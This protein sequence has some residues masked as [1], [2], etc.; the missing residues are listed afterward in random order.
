L[1]RDKHDMLVTIAIPCYEMQGR[2]AE[3]LDFGLSRIACQ[4]YPLIEVVISDHSVDCTLRSVCEAWQDQIEIHYVR[5]PSKRGSSSA[6]LNVA[7]HNASGDLVKILCQDDYLSDATSIDRT[8]CAFDPT[9][10]WLVTSYLH[11]KDRISVFDQQNPNMSSDIALTNTIG[12]HSCLTIRNISDPELF[13]EDLIWLMDC[14]YYRRL[15]DRFGSPSIL[16][17]VTV[18]QMLWDGQVTNNQASDARLRQAEIEAVRRRHPEPLIGL[19]KR[20][21]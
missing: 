1:T 9:S 5:N 19:S 16:H 10:S 4:T 14:E 20:R 8:V 21:E 17:D 18:V 6:N 12:T 7:I 11:T 13:D 3:F 2:G 15:Y